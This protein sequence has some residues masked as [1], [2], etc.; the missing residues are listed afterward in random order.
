MM[1]ELDQRMCKV[2]VDDRMS[3]N[4]V[5]GDAAAVCMSDVQ[6]EIHQ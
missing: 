4:A 2:L 6:K 5:N 3:E 1:N